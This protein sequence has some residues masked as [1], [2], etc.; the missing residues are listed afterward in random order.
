[1]GFR[2]IKRT[3]RNRIKAVGGVTVTMSL[4]TQ[5]SKK[6]NED[7]RDDDGR[8]K[9]SQETE[10]PNGVKETLEWRNQIEE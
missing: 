9:S 4:R 5:L 1:M 3:Q 10:C 8:Q 7:T 2:L 6:G